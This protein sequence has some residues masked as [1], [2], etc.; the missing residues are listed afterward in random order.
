MTAALLCIGTELT[1]GEIENGNATFLADRLT[2]LGHEVSEI[3]S[4]DDADL[5]I[6]ASLERL[7]ASCELLV[8]TGG[9]GPTSDD[10]TTACVAGVLGVDLETDA[11]SL[12]HIQELLAARGRSLTAANEKQARFPRGARILDN[13]LGTAPG[14]QV[15]LGACRA[16]FL[17]GVPSEMR[18][19]FER[20]VI[21]RLPEPGT[22]I[23]AVRVRTHGL[24]EALLGEQLA[25]LDASHEV[26][27]CYRASQGDVEVKVLARA[28]N[29][30]DLARATQR[31]RAVQDIIRDRL[32]DA[33]YTLDRRSL[34][35][36]LG[37]ELQRRGLSLGLAESC[38]GGLVSRLLTEYPGA[39]GYYKGGVCSY[40]NSVKEG[41]LG[42][43]PKT[44]ET[45]GAVSE[46]VAREMAIGA[47][48]SLGVDLALALTGIAGPEGGSPEKPVGLVHWAVASARQVR[49]EQRVF[50]GERG[51]IQTRA[52]LAGLWT[53][54]EEVLAS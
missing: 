41:V 25:D 22:R 42:V 1:R 4:V 3:V 24:P 52:A 20:G 54:R 11:R 48:R 31:A 38:T 17:P 40:A 33:V 45:Y 19:I 30:A 47:R 8:C 28:Q 32:G 2:E 21:P 13:P 50:S 14:F 15:Q 51:Q 36:S 12:Q 6:Q 43:L 26:T 29:A 9:L 7:A 34:A 27:L 35:A 5:R 16:F 10:R 23:V 37:D 18:A 53:V 39:T 49:T 46:E 44:L